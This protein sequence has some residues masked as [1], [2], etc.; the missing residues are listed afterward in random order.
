MRAKLPVI[1]SNV[2][3]V[4]ETIVDGETGYLVNNQDELVERLRL[5]IT[6]PD[7]RIEIGNQGRAS[8]KKNF[9]LEIQL[10]KTFNIYNKLLFTNAG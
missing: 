10:A 8:Y 2:G 5:L 6:D 4:G 7:K 1:A 9:T 3:G